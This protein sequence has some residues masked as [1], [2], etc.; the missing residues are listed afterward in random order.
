MINKKTAVLT[1]G[2]IIILAVSVTIAAAITNPNIF[3]LQTTDHQTPTPTPA[4]S[5]SST[6]S[7]PSTTPT[8]TPKPTYTPHPT[9]KVTPSPTIAPTPT[10]TAAPTSTP[11]PTPAPTPTPTATPVPTATPTPAPIPTPSPH[12]TVN[13]DSVLFSDDFSSEDTSAWTGTDTSGVTLGVING[14]L[15]CSSVV[16]TNG[17]WG[18]VYKWLNQTYNSINWRWY[19]FFGNLPSTDGNIIGGGGV[20][21]SAIE[22]N[23]T[24]SNGVCAVNVV[25]IDGV[26]HWNLGY[27]DGNTVYSLHSTQAVAT[28]TW[29]LVELKG[30]QGAGTGEVH[31][32]VNDEEILSAANLT[33]NHNLGID[34]VS[35]G[36]GISADQPVTWYCASAV[37]ST[38]HVGP[39]LDSA[40]L[41]ASAGYALGAAGLCLAFAQALRRSAIAKPKKPKA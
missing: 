8:S 10:P 41:A 12:P 25:R 18:Y 38:E 17:H 32:Y 16:P 30:V 4:I 37:A 6:N 13:P 21:N 27:V 40:A 7:T 29:Y 36:G 22:G 24:P 2:I 33:N 19:L 26:C 1:I 31:F 23:F 15:E 39:K 5:S 34:H 14:M 20:Y 28:Q 9:A 35:V 3:S 11:S